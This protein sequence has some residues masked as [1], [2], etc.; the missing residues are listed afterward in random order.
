MEHDRGFIRVLHRSQNVR[1]QL[2]NVCLANF[3]DFIYSSKA[4]QD[5][6]VVEL[7]LSE[8]KE[9]DFKE[10]NLTRENLGE[11]VASFLDV[12]NLLED[13]PKNNI[14]RRINDIVKELNI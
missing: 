11:Q 3:P 6:E 10:L 8:L 14:I 12:N 9:E 7:N 1:A 13:I 4:I 2:R 5:K